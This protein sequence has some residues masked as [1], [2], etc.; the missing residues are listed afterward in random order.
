MVVAVA[1]HDG[2]RGVSQRL[3]ERHDVDAGA[4]CPRAHQNL[5]LLVKSGVT[6]A[7]RWGP[8]TSYPADALSRCVATIGT[9]ETMGTA[10]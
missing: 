5:F 1:A 7:H 4:D 8:V 6:S 2:Q 9:I 3:L 10:S